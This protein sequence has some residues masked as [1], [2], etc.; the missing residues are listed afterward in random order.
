M[1]LVEEYL[2][3]ETPFEIPFNKDSIQYAVIV[4]PRVLPIL[5]KII[6]NVMRKLGPEWNLMIYGS[7]KNYEFI[8]KEILG[9]YF[10][11]N[12]QIENFCPKTYSLFLRSPDFW[13]RIPGE[14]VIL[15]QWDSFMLKP[16]DLEVAS[17][18]AK[19]AFVG[20]MYLFIH[21][22]KKIEVTSP[23]NRDFSING[24]F[25]YRKKSAM[26]DCIRRC[27]PFD[28]INFRSL[29]GLDV[30]YFWVELIT[31]EDVYFINALSVLGYEIPTR[32]E[33]GKFCLQNDFSVSDTCAIHNFQHEQYLLPGQL[34]FL[35]KK[36]PNM[37]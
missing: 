30:E 14:H 13:E 24:G 27:S 10:F 7:S 2:S 15:F 32:E 3:K 25:S 17:I 6:Y 33:C 23:H 11:L 26:L 19:Y 22:I 8:K 1:E 34:E 29:K 28:I 31:N 20:S 9:K 16:L 37:I 18:M 21:P 36:Y 35:L 5:P 12:T 4:E